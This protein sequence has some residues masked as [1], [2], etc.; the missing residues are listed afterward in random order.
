[1]TLE[2]LPGRIA[3]FNDIAERRVAELASLDFGRGGQ[4][5]NIILAP[6][7][8]DASDDDWES[9]QST[10]RLSKPSV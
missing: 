9:L 7:G 10:E 1:L 6:E 8:E 5:C 4:G 3:A 2:I